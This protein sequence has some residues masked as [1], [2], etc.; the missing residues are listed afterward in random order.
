[1]NDQESLPRSN[2]PLHEKHM[3]SSFFDITASDLPEQAF[4]DIR[5]LENALFYC[6]QLIE[7]K[8]PVS[9]EKLNALDHLRL[10]RFYFIESVRIDSRMPPL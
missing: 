4:N 7:A 6:A 1:M 9:R 8:A 5:E 3:L 10:A 2:K